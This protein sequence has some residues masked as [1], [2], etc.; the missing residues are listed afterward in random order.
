MLTVS[1]NSNVIVSDV[2]FKLKA[3]ITGLV[4]SSV[5]LLTFSESLGGLDTTILSFM[6]MISVCVCVMYV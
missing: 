1:E 3:L 2:K 5:K 4:V 6:S